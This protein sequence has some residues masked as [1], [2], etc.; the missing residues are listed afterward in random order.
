MTPRPHSASAF[1]DVPPLAYSRTKAAAF[2]WL[3][4][5]LACAFGQPS[6]ATPPT[7]PT[8]LAAVPAS[9]TQVNLTWTASTDNLQITSY[10]I[11]RCSGTSCTNFAQVGSIPSG[12]AYL[13]SGLAANTTY[14]YEVYATDANGAG[15][16]SN[17]A[18]AKTLAAS[19]VSAITYAYDALGRLIQA[20]VAANSTVENY[21][22]DSA[23]NITSIT[24]SPV[25]TLGV[26]N[27]SNAQGAPGTNI[28][29]VGSGF[30]ATP[31][32]DTVKFNGTTATVVSAT[33]TQLVVTVPAGATSGTV[34]V[35]TGGKTVTSSGSF[36]VVAATAA[37]TITSFP[38][39][40]TPGSTIVINGTGF[41]TN[42]S[43]NY[44]HI[45]LTAAQ[46]LSATA[47]ALTVAVPA[48]NNATFNTSAGPITVTTPYGSV[49]STTSFL[50]SAQS[51]SSITTGT[52]GGSA[53]NLNFA[54]GSSYEVALFTGTAG[55]NIA[56]QSGSG[57]LGLTCSVIGPDGTTYFQNSY[58][59]PG[60]AGIQVPTLTQNGTYVV[61]T[62]VGGQSGTASFSLL[63][64]VTGTLTLNGTPTNVSIP[65]PGQAAT[66]TFSGTQSAY[67]SLALSN[68]TLSSGTATVTNPDGTQ[69]TSFSVS[70]AA[71][72]LLPQL[73]QTGTYTLTVVPRGN[74]TGGF[75]AALTSAA[76]PTLTPNSGAYNLNLT[77]STPVTLTFDGTVGEYLA[78]AATVTGSLSNISVTVTDPYGAQFG[79]TSNWFFCTG[80]NPNLMNIGPLVKAGT[81]SITI[82]QNG[83][84]SGTLVLNLTTPVSGAAAI[85]GSTN[86]TAGI[87]GQGIAETFTGNAGQYV[88]VAASTIGN[89]AGITSGSLTLL[90][91]S[92]AVLATQ[93]IFGGCSGS[94]TAYGDVSFGP[95]PTTG[96][97]TVLM[98]QGTGSYGPST[99]TVTFTL[100]QH[101]QGTLTLGTPASLG[102]SAG[103]G[104]QEVFAGAAGQ[105][106]SIGL[107]G[108]PANGTI[109][110]TDPSG[111][112]LASGPYNAYYASGLVNFGPLPVSGNYAVIFNPATS[113]SAPA[114]GTITVSAFAAASGAL[115]FGS[116][117]NVS[118]ANGQ[119]LDET[120]SGTAG[121][122]VSIALTSTS[123]IS[124]GVIT[125]LSPSGAVLLT[126]NYT[127][128]YTNG[129][130]NISVGPLPV[131]GTYTVV[132]QQTDGNGSLAGGTVG[133][134]AMTSL[135][136][137][138]TLGTPATLNF[139][140][141]QGS[142]ETFTETAGDYDT[143]TFSET[144]GSIYSGTVTVLSPTGS[145]MGTVFF[146]Y[147]C[148]PGCTG[149]SSLNI[150]PLPATGTYTVLFQQA[151]QGPN[152]G[153]GSLTFQ[154]TNNP[155]GTGVTQNIS[156]SVAGA[157]QQF[158]Y[159]AAAKQVFG[160][161]FTNMTFTPS[162]VTSFNI[163][164][165]DPS[166]NTVYS[167]A[168]YSSA[169]QMSLPAAFQNGTYTVTVTPN[170]SATMTGTAVLSAAA[171][172]VL[173]IGT[174]LNFNLTFGQVAS[175]TFSINSPQTVALYLG[176]IATNPSGGSYYVEILNS[177][178]QAF[179]SAVTST[180][181]TINLPSLPADNYTVLAFSE[182]VFT[183]S[184][185]IS[186]AA[187]VTG[188]LPLNGTG[189]PISTSTPGENGY[190][191]F[192]GVAGQSVTVAASNVML[193]PN[194]VTNISMTGPANDV[195]G[196]QGGGYC[197]TSCTLHIPYLPLTQNYS[198]SFVPGGEA[199]MSLTATASPDVTA[200]LT[201]GVPLNLT[202]G[203]AGQSALLTFSILGE[204]QQS[205][206]LYINNFS[207]NPS[208]SSYTLTVYQLTSG[209]SVMKQGVS[210][211]TLTGTSQTINLPAL[212]A[213]TYIILIQPNS[214]SA[215]SLQI[216]LDA[217]LNV[218][219]PASGP[220]VNGGTTAPGQNAYLS[221]QGTAGQTL[222]LALTNLA[223]SPASSASLDVRAY[224]PNAL[225]VA[226]TS[227]S[228]P[229]IGC[230]LLLPVLPMTDTYSVKIIPTSTPASTFSFS[231]AL[232]PAMTGTIPLSTP[233][234]ESLS[235]VGQIG[236]FSFTA[237]SGQNMTITINSIVTVPSGNSINATVYNSSGTVVGPGVTQGS[238]TQPITISLSSLVAGTYTIVVSPQFPTT[239]TMQVTVTPH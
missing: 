178:N 57:T 3:L 110:L 188:S 107:S 26:A 82:Q 119:G 168:C 87:I 25:A 121:Q 224:T 126:A 102:V 152:R 103:Q 144:N 118:L 170:G 183:G 179:G 190:F 2:R 55:S 196:A 223:V 124:S 45:G 181:T 99:G 214:A 19:V 127:W 42:V 18:A 50:T 226:W 54:Q 68:V 133:V 199:T 113:S 58:L 132:F 222:S 83:S 71:V 94:C 90:N 1:A 96:S 231:A 115:T 221:F 164:V 122:Y 234:N 215:A 100:V 160:L 28:T 151:D 88:S 229:S 66:L 232:P 95:L 11:K 236:L 8:N 105:Y 209:N 38:P 205:P 47:T 79:Y 86:G 197:P 185:Q 111:N 131:T 44:V 153:S 176:N 135:T 134:T 22:Y 37:P 194:T 130:G 216:T 150:G 36:N 218:L 60:G 84:A 81:Y 200:T 117:S 123:S 35:T 191:T 40:S 173:T 204:A 203:E 166:S 34:S 49:T 48:T 198:V 233:T 32:N 56:I 125:V 157:S 70:G 158:T 220:T 202:L 138:L 67:V 201:S 141:Y 6:F 184:M 29:I 46:V 211:S 154:V 136:G 97:Y 210:T 69:L 212:A 5:A 159:S 7:A 149:N 237:S 195:F 228:V 16:V 114:A 93:T 77:N 182:G 12:T 155:A 167:N 217:M 33:T 31:A 163:A 92:G 61:L 187:G 177:A 162:S 75:T 129:A 235:I 169:C 72:T 17:I 165:Q 227:C 4:L 193:T 104:L 85:G 213:G 9:S 137:S 10:V 180:S 51:I 21:T 112:I 128:N 24:S 142:Q 139:T 156:T 108:S 63:G 27:L 52:I 78:L 14:R 120:F 39:T 207:T 62:S 74:L 43:D 189:V 109:L 143:L 13:D 76:T 91:A 89:A 148:N 174:P 53:I 98:Q 172:G 59:A 23:G 146:G 116:T 106:V 238:A 73:P 20:N 230:E 219:V 64:A 41:Q 171:G 206:T 239:E 208:N 65:A 161:A 15:P 147:S 80:C 101:L 175:P 140:N 186:L 192:A 225:Q 30:S 145:V